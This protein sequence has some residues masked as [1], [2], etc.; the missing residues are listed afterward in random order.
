MYCQLL[1]KINNFEKFN[2]EAVYQEQDFTLQHQTTTVQ[3][4]FYFAQNHQTQTIYIIKQLIITK[5]G[6]SFSKI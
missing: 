6:A 5:R 1:V 2:N 4:T 3:K